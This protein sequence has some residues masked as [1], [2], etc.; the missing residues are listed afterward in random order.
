MTITDPDGRQLV[1]SDAGAGEVWSTRLTRPGPYT[2]EVAGYEDET[3]DFTVDVSPVLAP[4]AVTTDL[5]LLVFDEDGTFL[6]DS[7]DINVATGRPLELLPISGVPKVQIVVS[8]SGRGEVGAHRLRTVLFGDAEL[9]EHAVA[10]DPGIFGHATARGA[11]AVAAYD[12]FRPFLPEPYSATGGTLEVLYG[13]DGEPLKKSRRQRTVPQVAGTDGGNST[14]FGSDTSA[15]VDDRPNFFGTSAAAPHVAGIAALAVQQAEKKRK[16]LSPS[17][18]RSRLEDATFAHDRD[19]GSADGTAAGVELRAEGTGSPESGLVPGSMTDAHF[20]TL[21]NRSG[22]TMRSVTLDGTTASPTALGLAGSTPSGGIVFDPRPYDAAEPR[23]RVG[24]PFVVGDTDGGLDAADVTASYAGSTGNG[25][26]RRLT[27][28]FADG[29]RRGDTLEFGVDRD[30]AR[31]GD[32]TADEGNGADELGGATVLPSGKK[33]KAG[34]TFTV[35]TTGGKRTS[36]QLRND[37]GSGFTRVDGHG[38]VDAEEA[39]V[40]R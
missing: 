32:G 20:F 12:P 4:S 19:P 24:F 29:L 22:K 38:L 33:D 30:L 16:T 25:Q 9:A 23:Q 11:T 7:A 13:S 37:L 39:V 15:D 8:R 17:T 36:G 1:R 34:L 2:V 40:G 26:F 6:G 10:S 5:N 14:F 18:L 27:L 28:T 35:R 31:S 21:R 3:G